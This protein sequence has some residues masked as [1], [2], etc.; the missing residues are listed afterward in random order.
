MSLKHQIKY[1]F[2]ETFRLMDKNIKQDCFFDLV[3]L[4]TDSKD[5]HLVVTDGFHHIEAFPM[6]QSNF[7]L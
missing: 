4:I 3:V 1:V 2:D 5:D 6:A 7:E